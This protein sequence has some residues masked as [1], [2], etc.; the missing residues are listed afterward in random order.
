MKDSLSEARRGHS[1]VMKEETEA[2]Q[3]MQ[4]QLRRVITDL[5]QD[6]RRLA[7]EVITFKT[8]LW[9][10]CLDLP[11][12]VSAY[13]LA[14]M[15]REIEFLSPAKPCRLRLSARLCRQGLG[16]ATPAIVSVKAGPR[17][18]LTTSRC[19]SSARPRTRTSG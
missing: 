2:R 13:F 1:S 16:G 8:T 10:L 18:L 9:C 4:R 11:A 19:R 6:R 5:Q 7:E 12:Q 17:F 14:S 15:P 3:Q